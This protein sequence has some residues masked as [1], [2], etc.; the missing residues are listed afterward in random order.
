M[1]RMLVVILMI[2][3]VALTGCAGGNFTSGGTSGTLYPPAACRGEHTAYIEGA[4]IDC[5]SEES[6]IALYEA[7][8][9]KVESEARYKA[10]IATKGDAAAQ[11][12]LAYMGMGYEPLEVE[13]SKSWDERLFPYFNTSI[14]LFTGGILGGGSNNMK[15]KGDGNTIHIG[16]TSSA[17]GRDG[18]VQ[19]TDYQYDYAYDYMYEN[20]QLKS[21]NANTG[22]GYVD[23]GR[24]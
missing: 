3:A 2:T 8:D 11:V 13:K 23:N 16:D 21:P 1:K 20:T 10:V 9:R 4:V 14:R 18:V 24:D 22:T 6:M 17:F 5:L 7:N 15:V 19:N 12:Q